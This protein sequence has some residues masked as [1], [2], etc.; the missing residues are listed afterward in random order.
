MSSQTPAEGVG[1]HVLSHYAMKTIF[2]SVLCAFCLFG[3]R[4]QGP[5]SDQRICDLVAAGVSAP[6]ILRIIASAPSVD[7]DL[8]PGSTAA[9]MQAG[10]SEETIK[11]MAARESGMAVSVAPTTT[12][13]R[14]NAFEARP[15]PVSSEYT[16]KARSERVVPVRRPTVSSLA[17]VRRIYIEKLPNDFDQYLRAEFFKQM[18]R[19][20]TIVIDKSDADAVINWRG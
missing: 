2:A 9:M 5:L 14:P 16:S 18:A 20:V 8:R 13:A 12:V 1:A 4:A 19:R 17:Q 15:A 6:E 11:A 7:F 10:V 3:Q